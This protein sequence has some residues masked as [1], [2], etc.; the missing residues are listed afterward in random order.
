V[1]VAWC[2]N[3]G[4]G[5]GS[6]WA[7]ALAV[8]EQRRAAAEHPLVPRAAET[9]GAG[10]AFTA[11]L[12]DLLWPWRGRCCGDHR[13]TP[14]ACLPLS[15]PAGQLCGR[16]ASGTPCGPSRAKATWPGLDGK[17]SKQT[18]CSHTQHALAMLQQAAST[19]RRAR[20]P[21]GRG[22]LRVRA[23][24]ERHTCTLA[25]KPSVEASGGGTN[26]GDAPVR[27]TRRSAPARGP[28]RAVQRPPAAT[29]SPCP[30]VPPSSQ[31]NPTVLRSLTEQPEAA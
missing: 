24:P 9:S 25:E 15:T 21:A 31:F 22:R 4:W 27:A 12:R 14:R 7:G 30:A 18:A 6:G 28:P 11:G 5:P 19:P 2:L 17:R 26:H 23:Q 16:C 13:S 10:L 3:G 1:S 29:S 20:A 8:A